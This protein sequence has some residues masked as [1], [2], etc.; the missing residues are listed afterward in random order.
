M[1]VCLKN[2]ILLVLESGASAH[3]VIQQSLYIKPLRALHK[4]LT[5]CPLCEP[6]TMVI[7]ITDFQAD[8]N[9]KYSGLYVCVDVM[10]CKIQIAYSCQDPGGEP[11]AQQRLLKG[12]V[13]QNYNAA[14]AWQSFFYRLLSNHSYGVRPFF[15]FIFPLLQDPSKARLLWQIAF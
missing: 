11:A 10:K 1:H 7:R 4:T 5:S 15:I 6:W 2:T 8:S 9:K 14:F 12:Q 3:T 13:T